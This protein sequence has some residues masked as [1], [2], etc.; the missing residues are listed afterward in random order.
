MAAEPES[1]FKQP[2][3]GHGIPVGG[4]IAFAVV[5]MNELL[6][7]KAAYVHIADSEEIKIRLIDEF[8]AVRAVH[9][10][11]RRR[12]VGKGAK[13]FRVQPITLAQEQQCGSFPLHYGAGFLIAG[14]FDH[15]VPGLAEKLNG[16]PMRSRRVFDMNNGPLGGSDHNYSK[17]RL[18][19]VGSVALTP[20]DG[21]TFT[22]LSTNEACR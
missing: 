12:T 5:G 20:R 7:F 2:A 16:R 1:R 18:K 8:A 9:P 6:P 10:E 13:F 22:E 15:Q 21:R 17:L 3:F 19:C 11:E 4:H 14:C